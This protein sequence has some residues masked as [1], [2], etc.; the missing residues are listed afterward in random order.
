MRKSDKEKKE[1][2]CNEHRKK[3]EQSKNWKVGTEKRK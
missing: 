1:K 3:K 2:R